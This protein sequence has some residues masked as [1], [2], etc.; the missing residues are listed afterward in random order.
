MTDVAKFVVKA[1]S[2]DIRRASKDLDKLSKSAHKTEKSTGKMTKGFAS[3]STVLRSASVA[4][5]AVSAATIASIKPTLDYADAIGKAADKIG[6]T[7]DELQELRFAGELSGVQI[8]SL[9]TSMQRFARRIGEAEKGTGVLKD[10]LT[11]LGIETRTSDGR[12]RAT[13]DILGDYANAIQGAK[14]SQERLRLAIKAF[15]IE[16]GVMVNM[17][18]NGK[19]GLDD[20]RQAARD[21]GAV[22]EEDLIRKAEE[23]NDKWTTLSHTM[24]TMF[25]SM[26]IP[27]LSAVI[28][29]VTKL[30]IEVTTTAEWFAA[31]TTGKV[32]FWEWMTTGQD[33][34]ISRL[35]QMEKE[36]GLYSKAVSLS[37]EKNII[38]AK[39]IDETYKPIRNS[40]RGS[41]G[42]SKDIVKQEVIDIDALVNKY[43]P[44]ANAVSNHN[45]QMIELSRIN[46]AGVISN[47]DYS[48]AV[49][50]IDEEF[51]NLNKTIPDTVVEINKLTE[52]EEEIIIWSDVARTGIYG[53][54]GS[55]ID[56]AITGKASL[57]DF[58]NSFAINITKMIA[59]KLAFDAIMGSGGSGGFLGMLFGGGLPGVSGGAGLTGFGSIAG[60]MSVA[61]MPG[62]ANGGS[63]TVGGSGGTDSQ[64]VGFKAT[65]GEKVSVKT[66][67]QQSSSNVFNINI[68]TPTG[69][70]SR[71]SLNQLQTRLMASMSMA[72]RRNG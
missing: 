63:F 11:N 71:E 21:A 66:P 8:R 42:S 25:R 9:G 37:A 18:K 16:G 59:Q 52:Q 53:I 70:L 29:M 40:K 3:M 35:K 5:A 34:A 10:E 68:S 36:Q 56:M 22:L 49:K 60:G 13:I 17:L 50:T 2:T 38:L 57:E 62:F 28:D 1:D 54:T 51:K 44:L 27:A 72:A 45:T 67:G 55:M 14:S 46:A 7:T 58:A 20:L 65:P 43:V 15:D 31:M 12:M 6:L 48:A 26:V 30:R 32:G 41:S 19:A 4:I 64:V 39:S 69:E 47:E 24:S 23:I 33:G 61:G